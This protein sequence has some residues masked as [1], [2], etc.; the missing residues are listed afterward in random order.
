MAGAATQT[1]GS[2]DL[3][4]PV[5]VTDA[6]FQQEVL[7]SPVP[8]VVDFWAPWCGPCRMIA[9][10]LERI[11]ADF[12]GRVKIAKVNVDENPRY[13]GQY[14]VQGIPTLLIVKDGRVVDRLVGALPEQ[15]LRLR[16][17]A[18]VK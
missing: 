9:P 6:T 3:T 14:G 18:Y 12:A 17:N 8:V 4:H 1:A 5:T 2:P 10:A 15:A 11:A 16:I 13:A 7:N